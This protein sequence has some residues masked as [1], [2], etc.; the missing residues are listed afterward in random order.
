LQYTFEKVNMSEQQRK[1]Y[2]SDAERY[3][4]LISREDHQE[5]IPRALDEIISAAGL[6]VVDLGA[7]TGRLTVMLAQVDQLIRYL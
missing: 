3:E 1:I 6:D 5:N 4:V 2:E 7:G